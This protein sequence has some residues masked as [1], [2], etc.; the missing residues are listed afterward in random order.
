[1][2]EEYG[3]QLFDI[4]MYSFLGVEVFELV[5][6][7]LLDRLSRLLGLIKIH[8]YRY[9]RLALIQDVNGPKQDHLR[10]EIHPLFI[11]K[12]LDHDRDETI[13]D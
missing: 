10:K 6:L 11:Y 5:R 2:G 4:T 3:V 1:M 8:L 9:D 7:Y 13:K 12:R